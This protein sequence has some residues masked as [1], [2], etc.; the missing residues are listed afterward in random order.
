MQICVDSLPL[1]AT[2]EFVSYILLVSSEIVL[3]FF[4]YQYYRGSRLYFGS[5]K[6]T[7]VEEVIVTTKFFAAWLLC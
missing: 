1:W 3:L 5:M 7:I 2:L 6:L 4:V